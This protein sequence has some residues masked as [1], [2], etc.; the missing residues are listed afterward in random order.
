MKKI[1]S[2]A[3]LLT[4]VV[5]SCTSKKVEVKSL[6][7]DY[8]QIL[9][10]T[11]TPTQMRGCS[12]LYTEQGSWMGFA[13]PN[14]Q[15]KGFV[16]PFD[17]DNRNWISREMVGLQD[18]KLDSSVYY[19]GQLALF[20]KINEVDVVQRLSFVDGNN[21]LLSFT[22]SEPIE[23]A[24]SGDV[25]FS[26]AGFRAEG[27]QLT[28]NRS[29]GEV[30]RLTLPSEIILTDS[31][32]L[33]SVD[34][35]TKEQYAYISFFND[36]SEIAPLP[37]DSPEK[38]LADHAELWNG[39]ISNVLRDDMPREYDRI[40]VKSLVT[41]ISN[42]RNPK[43]DLFHAGII[44][45]HAVN[46]FTGF[47]G[48][49]SWKHAVAVSRFDKEL[50]KNQIRAMFDYQD[51]TGMIIDCIY[52]DR[53]ENN[54]RDS[55]P[56]LAAW[57]IQAVGDTAFIQ[58]MYPRLLT[59]YKWWFANRDHDGNGICEFGSTDGTIEAAKWESGMDNAVRYDKTA[60]VKNNDTAWSF[61][62]ES[63]DLNAYLAYECAILKEMASMQGIAFDG[64]EVDGQ[65]VADYFF[66]PES[67]YY[68]DKT[69]KGKFVK[70]YGPEAFI[71]LW[72]GIATKAQ[73]DAAMVVIADTAKFSTYIPMPTVAADDP[74][75]TANGYW[76]GPIWLDQVYFGIS[77]IRKYGYAKEA[78]RYTDQV[79]TRLEGI[80]GG[81]AIHENYN[82]LTGGRL[83]APHFSWSAAHL[84]MLYWEYGK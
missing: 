84:L 15:G 71:P 37:G 10:I 78:D 13:L 11:F 63:V 43:G 2:I 77:G 12:G 4:L 7:L 16:G 5:V 72:T 24:F 39:Y 33:S 31:T 52:S 58:E 54:A 1:I 48:W 51:S 80:Q 62:Q 14:D 6:A 69:L 23:W 27:T 17:I 68:F 59:Y 49:D 56:P 46:Y 53:T 8:P 20:G 66:D 75:F 9:D 57:A 55:K 25:W 70:N 42:W 67:G 65:R 22:A 83:K 34:N 3:T 44:P 36:A 29:T 21:A 19:P 73:A 18:F 28:L 30:C 32:Y 64:P 60:M 74:G 81:G 41:L 76:R 82:T 38:L 40:A 50:A 26:D 79:F 45:S 35:A 47:W 61:D